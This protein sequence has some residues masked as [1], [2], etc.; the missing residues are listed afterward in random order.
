MSQSSASSIHNDNK[1]NL[2]SD[3]SYFKFNQFIF[4]DDLKLMGKMLHRFKFFSQTKHLPGDIVEMGV[5]KGSGIASFVKFIEIFCPNS[6]KK[7]IGFDIFNPE[8]GNFI[9]GK[10]DKEYDKNSMNAVY[11]KVDGS[12]LSLSS[13]KERLSNVSARSEDRVKLVQ[14]DI[15]ESLPKFLIEN[16]GF[17]TSLI[18][19]DV[20][21]ERPT[22]HALSGL[23]ERLLPGGCILFDEYEYHAFSE[24]NGVDKFLKEKQ[25]KYNLI[26]TDWIAPSAYMIKDN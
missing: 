24:S 4:S 8:E 21:I 17:R 15:Q 13:V 3:D 14:G 1:L 6:N 26:S 5:F 20:D 2:P 25:I 23:W 11:S 22:Y 9:L 12:E 16:P 7:V 19:I 10:K 18:Y